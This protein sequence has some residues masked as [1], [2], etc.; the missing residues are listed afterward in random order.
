MTVARRWE[1]L[2][3]SGRAWIT[4]YPGKR[5]QTH[6]EVALIEIDCRSGEVEFV[7]DSL[8]AI[9]QVVTVEH[10]AGGRDLLI[11]IFTADLGSLSR[12]ILERISRLPGVVSTRAQMVTKLYGDG[13][14]WR[15]RA[16]G[17]A[18]QRRLT[19]ESAARPV[20]GAHRPGDAAP[21]I[22]AA[23]RSLFPAAS[24]DGR[25]SIAQLAQV[26]GLSPT[27][28][29]RRMTRLIDEQD[30]KLRCEVARELTEWPVSAT[31]WAQVP[32]DQ[33]ETAARGLLSLAEVRLCTSVTGPNNL[34][35]T[36]WLR[37][38]SDVQRLE[39]KLAERLPVLSLVDRAIALRQT[40]LMGHL[41]APGGRETGIVPV[42]I[43][44]DT[45]AP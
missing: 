45:R 25:R 8:A 40:K 2:R 42:D 14:R 31:L 3:S 19:G 18:Q 1:R 37:S 7:A 21:A 9:P 10:M 16:L 35:F 26:T 15:L 22:D 32:A 20:H 44:A 39:A 13:S 41:V 34:L 5:L 36:V 28:V 12:L 6:I 27:T 30:M 23:S 33:L 17:E 29:R 24:A 4:A 38:V 11:T 43:W